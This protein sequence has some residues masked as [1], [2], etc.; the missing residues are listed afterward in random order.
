MS[1]AAMLIELIKMIDEYYRISLQ[2]EPEKCMSYIH[3]YIQDI[4]GV[5]LQL[6]PQYIELLT[7]YLQQIMVAMEQQDYVTMRDIMYYEVRPILQMRL[8]HAE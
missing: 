6:S 7:G 3:M 1:A 5:L 4:Q 2:V 8:N